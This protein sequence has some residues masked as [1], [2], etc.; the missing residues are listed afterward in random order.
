MDLS[1]APEG[2]LYRFQ[3]VDTGHNAAAYPDFLDATP[4]IVIESWAPDNNP[5][6]D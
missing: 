4:Y 2:L 3:V 6:A 5:Y 1:L